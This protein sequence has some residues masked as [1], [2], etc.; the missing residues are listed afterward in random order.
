MA[1]ETLQDVIRGDLYMDEVYLQKFDWR[2]KL[3]RARIA[4]FI[5]Y[6]KKHSDANIERLDAIKSGELKRSIYWHTW[7]DSGGDRQVFEAKYLYY[8]KFVELALGKNHKYVQIPA[9]Q[10]KEWGPISRPDHKPRKAKPF[11]TTEMR[12]QARRF[13]SYL[14]R[15]LSF[16]GM[17][18]MI[19]AAGDKRDRAAAINSLIMAQQP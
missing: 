13:E 4:R 2:D 17:G 11:V 18:Y 6:G 7:N 5:W 14:L 16:V 19:F 1:Q 3:V 8:E 9:I 15:H 10:I 12:K